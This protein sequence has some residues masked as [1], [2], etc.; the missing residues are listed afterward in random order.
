MIKE[1]LAKLKAMH[2]IEAQNPIAPGGTTSPKLQKI[3]WEMQ[4]LEE[5]YKARGRKLGAEFLLKTGGEYFSVILF[6]EFEKAHPSLHDNIMDIG[7]SGELVLMNNETTHFGNSFIF[8]TSNIGSTAID[9]LLRGGTKGVGFAASNGKSSK[10]AVYAT[11][12][13]E[14]KKVFKTEFLGRLQHDIMVFRALTRDEMEEILERLFG[15][16]CSDL[17]VRVGAKLKVSESLKN[18]ILE[19]ALEHPE[20]GARPLEQAVEH[21]L[22]KPLARLVNTYQVEYRDD[23]SASVHEGKVVF[24]KTTKPPAKG[25]SLTKT[26]DYPEDP[27]FFDEIDLDGFKI[28]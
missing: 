14:L 28:D 12:L 10:D 23:V 20:Y 18:H 4:D 7:D 21:M 5:L 16:I 25:S 22:E 3:I 1:K 9:K 8:L 24:E 15:K 19:D 6:D 13:E 11:V 2:D 27:P 17:R 26:R